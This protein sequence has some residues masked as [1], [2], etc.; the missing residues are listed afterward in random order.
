MEATS[1]MMRGIRYWDLG[2]E[3]VGLLALYYALEF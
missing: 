2:D 1:P 3:V